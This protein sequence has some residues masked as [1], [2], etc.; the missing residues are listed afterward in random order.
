M[1]MLEFFVLASEAAPEIAAATETAAAFAPEALAI[2]EGLGGFGAFNLGAGA[3]TAG[4]AKIS[5]S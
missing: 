1:P 4:M 5:P 2:G 3:T